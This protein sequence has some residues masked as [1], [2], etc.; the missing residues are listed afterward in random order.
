MPGGARAPSETGAPA[1]ETRAAS[2]DPTVVSGA[3]AVVASLV[4]AAC[5]AD[6][7]EPDAAV[8]ADAV[9]S[10]VVPDGMT[11]VSVDDAEVEVD[12]R[13]AGAVVSG[14]VTELVS[15]VPVPTT[16]VSAVAVEAEPV[17]SP[18]TEN[19]DRP[20]FASV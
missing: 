16:I 12:A 6:A 7:F 1:A 13:S 4:V 15:V 8:G 20:P 17:W 9:T 3:G 5:S 19:H 11:L 2:S 10:L 18:L 14:A